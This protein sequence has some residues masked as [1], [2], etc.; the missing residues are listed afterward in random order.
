MLRWYRRHG[1]D[2][3][4]RRTKD[5]YPILVSEVMLQQTQ[6]DRVV[7]KFEAFILRFPTVRALAAAPLAEVLRVWSGLGYNGR[8]RRLWECARVV[9]RSHGGRFPREVAALGQL[10]GVGPYTAGALASF[11]FGAREACVDTNIRRV[12]SRAIDGRDRR[13]ADRAWEL[14]RAALPRGTA[15]EWH[16][17]LMDIGA[18]YC[19]PKPR[20]DACP[21]RR[22]C[23]GAGK[24]ARREAA[25]PPRRTTAY[26]GS[27]RFYRG[28][29][30]K[31]LARSRAM[32]FVTLGAEVAPGFEK[33]RLPW[34][35]ELLDELEREGLITIDRRRATARLG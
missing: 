8:A 21:I 32:D 22:H 31:A 23:A 12:L 15:G 27:R 10:P 24:A 35:K 30:V 5:P 4:W 1:R 9:V 13:D 25:T 11:A 6:V 7:P 29:I 16:Q 33:S 20:C 18:L 17:A 2:L 26:A 14:A 28:K 3:P 19:R 34:L